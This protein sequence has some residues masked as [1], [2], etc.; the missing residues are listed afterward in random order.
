MSAQVPGTETHMP[1]VCPLDCPDACSLDVTVEAGRVIAVGGSRVNP[2]TQGYICS[3]VRRF[4]EHVHGEG[5]VLYPRVREGRKG[6]GRFRRASWDEALG[7]VARK[8]LEVRETMGGEAILPMS[9]GG[10]NGYVSHDSADARLFRRLGA[11]NL[12]RT[13]CAAPSGSAATGLTGKMPGIALQDYAHAKIVVLWGVNPSVSGIHLLPYV[14]EAVRGGAK[15]VVI[16]PRRTKLAE[17]ADLHLALHPGTDLPVALSVIRWFFETGQAASEFLARHTTGAE[18]LARRAAPWSFARAA[19][20]AR[21]PAADIERFAEMY[22]EASPAA[23]RCGWGLERNRNGG[24]AIASVLALPAVAGKFGVRGGG[25]TMSNSKAFDIDAL[26]AV[27]A[28]LP[29]TREINM[30]QTGEV[31]LAKEKPVR[32]LFVYNNNPLS[33]LPAQAKVRRGLER[34]DL[35]TVVFDPVMTDTALYADVVLPATTF[36]ER[37]ELSRGYGV[38]ALQRNRPSIPPVGESRPNHEVFSALIRLT[39]LAEPGDPESAE[40][41]V[42]A[43]LGSSAEKGALVAALDSDGVAY[44]R[45]MSNPV[46]FVDVFPRTPDAKMH[47]VPEDLDREAPE[48]LY[49]YRPDPATAAYPLALISPASD[50]M[51]SSTLG[52][53]YRDQVRLELF[54]GD[55][56]ARGIGDG[57]TARVWNELGEVRC[58]VRL[59]AGL[60]PGVAMLPKGLWRH[61]TLS[62]TGANALAPDTLADLGGGACFNDARV[63]V[64]RAEGER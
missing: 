51:I 23:L 20:M 48:G 14:Q 62:G 52:E 32:L 21:V 45:G 25:Y 44:P 60:K 17:R 11:S 41:I 19:E 7:L 24:S 35:F 16:D 6:E 33:T 49:A 26:A 18:E 15:L 2:V 30:N 27:R 34:E 39:N 13:V 46:Q 43:L 47:L 53:L 10:S 12:A 29:K 31:L 63:E 58:L 50:R 3:K 56:R 42:T 54:P 61:H 40:E 5:R 37:D 28:P 9:Y 64:E 1:A 55:A 4:P 8:L 22:A 59:N 57:D 36:L 38:M